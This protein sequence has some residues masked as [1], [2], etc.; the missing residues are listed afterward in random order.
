MSQAERA[1]HHTVAFKC[2]QGHSQ[3]NRELLSNMCMRHARACTSKA[4][5]FAGEHWL[6]RTIDDTAAAATLD[7]QCCLCAVLLHSYQT[8]T[9]DG[10]LCRA[11]PPLIG[12]DTMYATEISSWPQRR[13]SFRLGLYGL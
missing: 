11:G 4:S 8:V 9:I 5:C 1:R 3:V 12:I 2:V 10:A 13:Y 7:L 6:L